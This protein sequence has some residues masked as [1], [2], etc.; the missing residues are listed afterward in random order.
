[1]L[2]HSL[3][4]V[5]LLGATLMFFYFFPQRARLYLLTL[6]DIVFY[7]VTGLS[8]LFLFM[9]VSLVVYYCAIKAVEQEQRLYIWLGV[10][11]AV[12]NLVFFK[13]TGFILANITMLYPLEAF[14]DSTLVSNVV[15]P[16]GISF[17]TFQ[18]VAYLLD[19]SRK[20][21]QPCRNLL[22]FWVFVSF[23]G[24]L[25]AGPIMRGQEFIPQ[26]ERINSYQFRLEDIKAGYY[27]ILL[28]LT[29]KIII[30]DNLAPQVDFYFGSIAQLNSVEAWI[31]AYL[32]AFQLY[33]DFSAYSDIAV[34]IGRLFGLRIS[35]NFATPYISANATEFW[36]RWHITLSTWIRDY[37]YIPLGGSRK[38]LL[39]Q[40][41]FIIV[42][43]AVSGLWHGAAWTFVLWGIYHGWL[44]TGHKLLTVL[45]EKRLLVF[46]DGLLSRVGSV[47]IFFNLA[48]IG[49]VFFR[50]NSLHDGL[51]MTSKMLL[52]TPVE[53]S[54][55]Y[56]YSF[57]LIAFLYL[58]HVVEYLLLKHRS[59][60]L[61]HWENN[62][63][64]FLRAGVYIL[65]IIAMVLSLQTGQN[66]FIYFQF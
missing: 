13:Y 59:T 18:L 51:L 30:A 63:P 55:A 24:K 48:T 39:L 12:A 62:V 29:K 10:L 23:F 53:I 21:I 20:K 33:F 56:M 3:E 32:F 38:G 35:L 45:R 42:A 19:V 43:M 61:Y 1:M 4:F 46:P 54:R 22:V 26:L 6:A 9:T 31:A 14:R 7:L 25:I 16:L 60:L 41:L 37:I 65:L 27:Y 8:Y 49:W 47:F 11:V 40:C 64:D 58:L 34:G 66:S 28:G 15:L 2:F 17:Y 5:L 57:T 44:L 36:K 50:A 52:F